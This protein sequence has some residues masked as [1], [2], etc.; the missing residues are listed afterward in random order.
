MTA[1]HLRYLV[2][3]VLLGACNRAPS[4]DQPDDSGLR[5]VIDSTADTV[6]ARIAGQVP[7][8]AIRRLVP[9][10]RIA[11]SA[12]DT[13]LFTEVSEFEVDRAGRFWVFDRP[14]SS[15]F[16]FGSDGTLIKRV[17]RK[18]GGPGE[19]AS[20]SGMVS[21]PDTGLAVWDP[22]N[23]RIS[24]FDAAGAFRT[25]W[26]TPSGFNT[27]NGLLTDGSGRLYLKRPVTPPREGEI[28]GRLGLVALGDRGAFRDSLEPPDLP[29]QREVYLAVQRSGK[30][31]VNQS[32][33]S[34]RFAP[35]YFWAWHPAG[36]FVVGHGG[37]FE[38]VV[39]RPEGK[40]L[41]IR[42]GAPAVAVA[43]EEREEEQALITYSMRQTQPDWAWSGPPIP[44][45]KAPLLGLT[46]ARDGRIWAQV[47]VPSERIPD[48]EVATPRDAKAP[49]IRHRTRPVYE[50]FG[51]DGRF[52][53]RVDC[54]CR[55]TLV[56]A[57]GDR[58]WALVRDEN[59]LPV[60]ARFRIEPALR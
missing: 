59:D 17:G 2:P 45:I 8:A 58:V 1:R 19:F 38:I 22:Q 23:A 5:T 37:R 42:R 54:G 20:N 3:L 55:M 50:V 13:S 6:V 56:D 26:V 28:L 36:Y 11:P 41:V 27:G 12:D 39:A 29:V 10:V 14:T 43:S 49:T 4:P 60:V 32:S 7:V 51:A 35:N 52:L 46:V 57:E 18:G 53:G 48:A 16:L 15:V 33:T 47:A 30:D 21:L 44:E 40:P 25:S 34:S 9:E 31:N 24:F